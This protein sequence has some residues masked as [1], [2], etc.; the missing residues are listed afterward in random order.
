MINI[1]FTI[2][3]PWSTR[4]KTLFCKHGL[5]WSATRAWEVNGYA[6]HQLVDF[7]FELRLGPV[8]HPGMFFMVGLLGYALEFNIYDTRHWDREWGVYY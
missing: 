8:D 1:N 4:W 3:N 6:T 2:D 7:K 5:I